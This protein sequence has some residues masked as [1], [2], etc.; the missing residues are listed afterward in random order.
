MLLSIVLYQYYYR[1]YLD[2]YYASSSDIDIGDNDIVASIVIL[3]M[4]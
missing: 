1:Q 2:I 4:I 3:I